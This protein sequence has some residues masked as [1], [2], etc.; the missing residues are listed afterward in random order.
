[1][2]NGILA[3]WNASTNTWAVDKSS[4]GIFD[5]AEMTN[6]YPDAVAQIYPVVVGV[7]APTEPEAVNAY[8]SLDVA[9]PNWDIFQLHDSFPGAIVGYAATV[10]GASSRA[11][12]YRMS[13][14]RK[15][16]N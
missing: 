1:M 3:F 9:F 4:S 14:E 5:Q 15:F 11:N 8:A 13:V 7:V 12:Q 16:V 6:W 10:M 2:R